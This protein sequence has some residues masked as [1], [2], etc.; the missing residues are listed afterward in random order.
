MAQVF[1]IV[2]GQS[3]ERYYKTHFAAAYQPHGLYFDVTVMPSKRGAT[4]RAFKGGSISYEECVN[5]V[6][7]FL[8]TAAHCQLVALVYDY[9]GLHP[10]FL[11]GLVLPAGRHV[12]VAER[13]AAIRQ[14]LE[15]DINDPRFHCYLQLHEFEAFLY[16]APEAVAR[17]FADPALLQVLEATLAVFDN[18]PEAINDHPETAPSKRLAAALQPRFF[19]KTTD[20][21][22]IAG[23]IGVA[24]LRAQCPAFEVFCQ[25]LDQLT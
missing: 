24:G 9:Y 10:S 17:H 12:A 5:N 19:G 8:R 20:G 21:V 15:A 11:A 7:R 4:S 23:A 18:Q 22:A 16:C 1:L 13:V 2:E 3:E 25:R 6:R 14:R